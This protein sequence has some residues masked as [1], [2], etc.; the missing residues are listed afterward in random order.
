MNLHHRRLWIAVSLLLPFGMMGCAQTPSGYPMVSQPLTVQSSP[1][2]SLIVY[3]A[4]DAMV[5]GIGRRLPTSH[6]IVPVSFVNQDN[7]N[8][9][10]SFGRLLS[11]QMASRFTQAGYSMVEV[12]LRKN[13]LI[14][15][16]EGEF[17]LSRE[18][19]KIDPT[20]HVQAVLAGSYTVAKNQIYVNAQLI[21]IADHVI[22][23]S[24]DFILPKGENIRVLLDASEK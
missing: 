1:D 5:R 20:L 2:I 3:N 23:A 17:M 9:T 19:S 13:L 10:S 24:Q 18:L 4:A 15:N 12:K 14:R 11:R 6:A 7:L 21:R 8:D 22:L 16:Q